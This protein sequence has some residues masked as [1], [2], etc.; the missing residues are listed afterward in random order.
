MPILEACVR[1]SF[2]SL[3]LG[4]KKMLVLNAPALI[5]LAGWIGFGFSGQV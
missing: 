1:N 3:I 2:W 4:P 5:E